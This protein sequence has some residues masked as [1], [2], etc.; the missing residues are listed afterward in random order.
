M[1]YSGQPRL[2]L[3]WAA[4]CLRP[5]QLDTSKG[6]LNSKEAFAAFEKIRAEAKKRYGTEIKRVQTDKG[7]EFMLNFRDGLRDLSE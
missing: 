5:P 1:R 7:S 3:A 2:V 4:R 6:T